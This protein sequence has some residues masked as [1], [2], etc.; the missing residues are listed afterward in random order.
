M[1]LVDKGDAGLAMSETNVL[2]SHH[3]VLDKD[4]S[5]SVWA[6]WW[7]E[8]KKSRKLEERIEGAESGQQTPLGSKVGSG[9]AQLREKNDVPDKERS[10]IDNMAPG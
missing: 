8:S 4:G 1:Y 2:D 7:K 5:K 10:N 3:A 9:Q 6:N